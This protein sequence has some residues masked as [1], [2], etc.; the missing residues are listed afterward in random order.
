MEEMR[1]VK[2][3]FLSLFINF[4]FVSYSQE[5]S[6][7]PGRVEVIQ[8]NK[9]DELLD[10][11]LYYCQNYRFVPGYRIQ[12]FFDSGN[13]SKKGAMATKASFI[14]KYPDVEAYLIFQEPH[15]KVRVGD[16]RTRM[17]AEGFLEVIIEEFPNAYRVND[18]ISFPEIH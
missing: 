13:N 16:F 8:D 12:I 10:K 7:N 1:I 9:L 2:I 6:N 3:V 11:Y 5:I 15:Y 18:K 4:F 14:T 17:E